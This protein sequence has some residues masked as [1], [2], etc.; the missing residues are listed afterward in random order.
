MPLADPPAPEELRRIPPALHVLPGGTDLW[1]IYA[2]GGA[3]PTTWNAFRT[4]GPTNLR[5]DHHDLPAR[6]QRRGILYAAEQALTCFAEVFQDTRTIDCFS[7]EP[8]LVSFSTRAPLTLLDLRGVWPT[9]AG[10][11]Q[12]INTGDREKARLWSRAFYLAYPDIHGLYYP[13]KM[14][15]GALSIA[16]YERARSAR[17]TRPGFHLPLAA[18]ELVDTIENAAADLGY[19]VI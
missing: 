3:Y 17:P 5:F 10:A 13:S 14:H 4:Y 6:Q 8:W 18:D 7:R 2:R 9:R 1:R 16:L 12:E 15:G 11:S 19:L